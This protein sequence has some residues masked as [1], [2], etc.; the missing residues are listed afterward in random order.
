M[1]FLGLKASLIASAEN[2]NKVNIIANAKKAESPNHGAC[3]LFLP[4]CNISPNEA[5]PAG[6]PNPKK[7]RLVRVTIAPVNMKGINDIADTKALG[8]IC[9]NII[10]KLLAPRARAERT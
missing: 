1:F 5:L 3:K 10:V 4:C 9:L 2:V 8:N 6:K 7:S